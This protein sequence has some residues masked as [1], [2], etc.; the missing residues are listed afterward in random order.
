MVNIWLT[1]VQPNSF[2]C[3]LSSPLFNV[4]NA[5]PEVCITVLLL[6]LACCRLHNFSE[7]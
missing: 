3:L 1:I 6:Y 5:I 2:G 4:T 7:A